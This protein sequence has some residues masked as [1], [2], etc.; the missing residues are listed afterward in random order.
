MGR[1]VLLVSHVHKAAREV[2]E[3][4]RQHEAQKCG[5][6][7]LQVF[8]STDRRIAFR[9]LIEILKNRPHGAPDSPLRCPA[10]QVQPPLYIRREFVEYVDTGIDQDRVRTRYEDGGPVM[11][12][13]W[14]P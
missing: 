12:A 4:D 6:V 3:D 7:C 2:S 5:E 11:K 14:P 10:R 1:D 13:T 9:E 8:L